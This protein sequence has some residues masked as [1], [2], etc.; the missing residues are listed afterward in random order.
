MIK[1][2][3]LTDTVWAIILVLLSAVY[4][5]IVFLLT[6]IVSSATGRFLASL[7]FD[8]MKIPWLSK[9]YF[10]ALLIITI[11]PYFLKDVIMRLEKRLSLLDHGFLQDVSTAAKTGHSIIQALGVA[12]LLGTSYGLVI[13]TFGQRLEASDANTLSSAI[14]STFST[15]HQFLSGEWNFNDQVPSDEKVTEHGM[16]LQ[17]IFLTACLFPIYCTVRCFR[18]HTE[19]ETDVNMRLHLWQFLWSCVTCY[20]KDAWKFRRCCMYL[21]AFAYEIIQCGFFIILP[22][23]LAVLVGKNGI[24]VVTYGKCAVL[25]GV[26]ASG[27]TLILEDMILNKRM[28]TFLKQNI[29]ARHIASALLL[30]LASIPVFIMFFTT[31]QPSVR[32]SLGLN[33]RTQLLI[34][35][36][37]VA[38][39]AYG[40]SKIT[41]SKAAFMCAALTTTYFEEDSQSLGLDCDRKLSKPHLINYDKSLGVQK[42][43]P[44]SPILHYVLL[45]ED[46]E[47]DQ[48]LI[49]P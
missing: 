47:D 20:A 1:E 40:C 21:L 19:E 25:Y 11:F 36:S 32:E 12:Y 34:C 8:S 30:Y 31:V 17:F 22:L 16:H 35:V 42:T 43:I 29:Q 4:H 15:L 28:R 44:S 45:G 49:I 5:G 14:S 2:R 33:R 38:Y 3:W 18:N 7:M 13:T 24:N 9:F 26:F 41:I 6:L 37:S 48:E 27:S 23:V 39:C 46:D 10:D